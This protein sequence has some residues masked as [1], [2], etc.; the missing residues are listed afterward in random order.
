MFLMKVS[1]STSVRCM[2]LAK[3]RLMN[4]RILLR[5]SKIVSPLLKI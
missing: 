1:L 3:D 2:T 4:L 5:K